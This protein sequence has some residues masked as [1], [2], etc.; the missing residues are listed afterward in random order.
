LESTTNAVQTIFATNTIGPFVLTNVLL[1][2]LEDTAK[3]HGSS[4]IVVMASSLHAECQELKLADLMS[5]SPVEVDGSW[6]FARRYVSYEW[7]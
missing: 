4:R 7:G 2:T 1:P 5:G 6:R 3:Q